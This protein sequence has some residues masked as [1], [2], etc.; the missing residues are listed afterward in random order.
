MNDWLLYIKIAIGVFC[1][2]S[3]LLAY[4]SRGESRLGWM[5]STAGWA[6]ALWQ[7]VTR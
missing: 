3:A 2:V 5:S 1:G 6:I 4:V 7:I